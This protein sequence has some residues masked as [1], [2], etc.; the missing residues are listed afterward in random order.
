[1][2]NLFKTGDVVCAKINPTQPL[3]VRVFARGVYYCDVKNHP[4]EKE[5]VYFERE[6]KVFSESQTL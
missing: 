1:M 4:E 3:V 2:N 5:Q 6:I